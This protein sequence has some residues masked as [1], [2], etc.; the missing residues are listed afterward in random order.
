MPIVEFIDALNG[1]L[2]D[3]V[4]LAGPMPENLRDAGDTYSKAEIDALLSGGVSGPNGAASGDIA[5]YNG[6]TGKLL[7]ILTR[8]ELW[9]L[10]KTLTNS[11]IN[12]AN[13]TITNLALSMFASGIIDADGTLAANSDS[14]LATQKAVKTY[15]DGLIEAANALQYKGT[16]DCSTN[17]NYPAANAG[18]WYFVSVAGKI[19][20]ASG[21]TVEVGDTILCRTD[22]SAAGTQAAVGANWGIIQAN[23]INALTTANIGSTVQAWDA[24]L[25]SI[26]ALS[27]ANNDFMQ[28]KSSA[29]TFR[30]PT[31]V[32]ADLIA[33]VGDS[34]SGGTKGLVP[35]PAAGDASANKFLK[36]NGTW[37]VAA[38]SNVFTQISRQ[39]VST[40]VSQVVFSSLPS[41][42]FSH[43]VLV[44]TNAYSS[45]SGD[46]DAVAVHVSTDNG[47][48][49]NTTSGDYR[50]NSVARTSLT[51]F[52]VPATNPPSP[53]Y[54]HA[55]FTIMGL[56]NSARATA[57]YR[58]FIWYRYLTNDLT[59]S[60]PQVGVQGMRNATE[61][62]NALRCVL[63][64]GN[65][66]SGST[67]ILYGV[68]ET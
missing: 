36:A 60:A 46:S 66:Q 7:G 37:A 44:V 41:S 33:M 29:W 9:A 61:Q 23:L 21:I 58:N 1:T 4:D 19:G 15:A 10:T 54:Q 62:D 47:S 65:F 28:R 64:S 8:D 38:G 5:I 26:A 20:G 18:H 57:A 22:G 2:T 32:T 43:F 50:E 16:I 49:W 59:Y 6:T 39:V 52:S 67:F 51:Q 13:N 42:G 12:G 14:K 35:A 34:G 45:A 11:T 24:D 31:Q 17:P 68:T 27:P 30:T 63:S 56:G 53:K 3:P 55:M 48:T 25:D 40:A